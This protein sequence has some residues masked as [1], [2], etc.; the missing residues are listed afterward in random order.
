MKMISS[1]QQQL[2]WSLLHQSAASANDIVADE[3]K[4]FLSSRLFENVSTNGSGW[5]SSLLDNIYSLNN[6]GC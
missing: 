2:F 6:L 3:K 5:S 1:N 4:I